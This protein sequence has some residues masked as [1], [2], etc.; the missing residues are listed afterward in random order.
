MM[1]MMMMEMKT[2][3]MEMIKRMI[4]ISIKNISYHQGMHLV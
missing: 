1:N 4:S 3:L 2:I